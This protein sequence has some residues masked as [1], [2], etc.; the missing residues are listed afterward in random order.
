MKSLL[1]FITSPTEVQDVP[2]IEFIYRSF[3]DAVTV[4]MWVSD[5]D[6]HIQF[7]NQCWLNF[8]GRELIQELA[9]KWTGEEVHPD[10]WSAC[11]KIYTTK[12]NSAEAFEH[13]Y[14]LLRYDGEYR[15]F[16]EDVRPYFTEGGDHRGFVATC[17]DITERKQA[18]LLANK[19]LQ[20]KNKELE[21][22][23]YVASHDLQEPLRKIQSFGELLKSRFSE[24]LPE[25]A[26]DYI[27]RMHRSASRMRLLIDDLLTY[28]RISTRIKPYTKI[29]LNQELKHVISDLEIMIKE[30]NAEIIAEELPEIYADPSQI[31]QLLM[32]LISNGIKYHRIDVSP[33]V[34]ITYRIDIRVNPAVD[35]IKEVE[36]VNLI[37]SD[38]G[39]GLDEQYAHKIFEPFQR[40]H[41]RNE[42]EGSGIG[43]AICKKIIERHKGLFSVSSKQTTGAEF[44]ATLPRYQVQGEC[45]D[46]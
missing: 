18:I 36:M 3:L 16:H 32:N 39:I 20:V 45:H 8:T 2:R 33:V 7:F 19:E 21:Q 43:L 25:Q 9:H 44:T 22:F 30:N 34:N 15:W 6:G 37:I 11:K 41:G 10:D 24:T 14:R 13:E 26:A 1:S 38:N 12:F 31:R 5:K 27:E 46:E 4:G 17:I 40:L 29:D 28:S 23:A 42:Y 35:S